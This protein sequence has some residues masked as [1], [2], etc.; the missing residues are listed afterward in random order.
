L[1][2]YWIELVY[3]EDTGHGRGRLLDPSWIDEGVVLEW[4]DLCNRHHGD[5]C[6]NPDSL[7]RVEPVQ[8]TWLIDTTDGCLVPG[9][10]GMR[11]V[12]LSY[13]RGAAELLHHETCSTDQLQ[14]PGVLLQ[15]ELGSLLPTT[16]KDA[17]AVVPLLGERFLWVDSLCMVHDDSSLLQTELDAMSRIYRSSCRYKY[18]LLL[19]VS[20]WTF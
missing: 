11:Y 16:I 4:K 19:P 10:Q 20:P 3:R 14:K 2:T 6:E 5:A 17:I 9:R 13:V 7:G 18:L 8:P 15:G 1:N 12:A